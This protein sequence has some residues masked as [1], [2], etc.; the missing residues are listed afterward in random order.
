MT[1]HEGP[2]GGGSWGSRV[3]CPLLGIEWGHD[4]ENIARFHDED[5]GPVRRCTW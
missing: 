3:A 1:D 4:R 5:V 2:S